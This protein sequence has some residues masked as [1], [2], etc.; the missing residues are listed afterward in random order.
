VSK[1]HIVI[2]AQLLRQSANDDKAQEKMSSMISHRK[3]A[4]QNESSRKSK[5]NRNNTPRYP[6]SIPDLMSAGKDAPV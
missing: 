2:A 6:S 4:K 1:Q 3:E 5:H